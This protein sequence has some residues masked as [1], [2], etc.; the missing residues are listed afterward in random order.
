MKILIFYRNLRQGGVQ[1]MMVNFANHM[2]ETGSE[3][4]LLLISRE[5]EFL[6]LVKPNVKIKTLEAN[7][8]NYLKA[9][10]AELKYGRYDSM[11]T[12]T[13]TLNTLSILSQKLSG[14]RT[15]VIISERSDTTREFLDG[16][17]KTYKLSFLLIPLLYRFAHAI[18]AVSKGVAS[19][20]GKFAWLDEKKIHVIYNPAFDSSQQYQLHEPVDEPWLEKK[21]TQVVISAGRLT[22]QKNFPLLFNAVKLIKER[23]ISLRLIII[24]DGPLRVSLQNLI[25]DLGLT[26]NVKMVGFKINPIAWIS[27]SDVFVMSS[28]W[29]GFGNILVDALASGTTIVSTAC[30]SGPAEILAD[31]KYGYLTSVSD[32]NEMADKI[33]YALAHPMPQSE[34]L[35]RA[36]SFE[37]S[38][39]MR[40]Y[41]SLF[42]EIN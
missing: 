3:V 12:A 17:I 18:V 8:K 40:K 24:G 14:T 13:P 2:I 39:I 11:F 35:E 5:G 10:V 33:L 6:S 25:D 16:G 4:T 37:R 36:K 32:P 7:G 22:E 1:R 28:A 9:L 31:G 27:K 42:A 26:E 20:L 23:G 30:K 41:E 34:L 15:R 19:G 38:T 21:E 29:E